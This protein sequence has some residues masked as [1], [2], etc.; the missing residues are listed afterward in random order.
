MFAWYWERS[1]RT[2]DNFSLKLTEALLKIQLQPLHYA[3]FVE[4]FRFI[5]VKGFPYLVYLVVF[6]IEPDEFIHVYAICH[7]SQEPAYWQNRKL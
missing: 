2:T 7:A 6:S 3:C 5:R 1:V 4:D